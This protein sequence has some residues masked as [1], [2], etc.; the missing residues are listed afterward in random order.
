M[1][2]GW[3][4]PDSIIGKERRRQRK[5]E[6]GRAEEE[7]GEEGRGVAKEKGMASWGDCPH[8]PGDCDCGEKGARVRSSLSNRVRE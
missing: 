7:R 6:D 3:A 1:R 5:G 2:D 4:G 8:L